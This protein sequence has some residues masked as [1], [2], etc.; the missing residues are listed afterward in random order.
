M[1]LILYRIIGKIFVILMSETGYVKT[2]LIRKLNQL[3][4]KGENT[5]D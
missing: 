5:N 2:S 1:V 3:L 4:N